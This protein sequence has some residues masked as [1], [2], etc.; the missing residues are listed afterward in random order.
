[1]GTHGDWLPKLVVFDIDYT[2]WPFWVD[3]HVD[4]PFC[5]QSNGNVTDRRGKRIKLY[6]DVMD[7]LYWLQKKSVPLA[8][9]SRTNE[10]EAGKEL[11]KVLDIDKFFKYKEI[12]PGCKVTHFK[13]FNKQSGIAFSQ[14]LFFDDEQRNIRDISHLGVTCI[15]VPDGLS[16]ELFKEGLSKYKQRLT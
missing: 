1:M 15:L 2:L 9:A 11:L 5:K 8:V 12:Y 3:T 7:V 4:P 16:M 6:H 13:E 14:M 10:P